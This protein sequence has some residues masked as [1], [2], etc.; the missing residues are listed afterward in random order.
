M[1]RDSLAAKRPFPKPKRQ[2]YTTGARFA[3][4]AA[5]VPIHRCAH[6]LVF[7]C[8]AVLVARDAAADLAD[9]IAAC[10]TVV[11][12]DCAA[13]QQAAAA[14]G[15]EVA[16][17]AKK[18][19]AADTAAPA[20]VKLALA[21]ALLDARDHSDA[22]D[23]AA[24][25]LG[26]APEA[27]DVRAAQARLG[28]GRAAAPLV[29]LLKTSADPHAKLLAAGGLGLLRTK[30]AVERLTAMLRDPSSQLQAEAARALGSIGDPAAELPLLALAGQPKVA[31]PARAAALAALGDLGSARGAALAALLADH[32]T[33]MVAVAALDV[34]R[35]QWKPWMTPAAVAAVQVPG[36]RGACARLALEHGVAAL[37]PHL[38]QVLRK[39]ESEPDEIGVVLLAVA[40]FK[41][42]GAAAAMVERLK[43]AKKPEKIELFRA[44]P[45][46]EDRTVVPDLVPWLQDADNQV[47]AHAVYAL[48]NLTG[49]H[50]GPDVAAWRAYAGL[51][52]K[53][54]TNPQP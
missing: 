22:L 10:P 42:A 36:L 8:A 46:V 4:E 13:L 29:D 9:D 28:D 47:V 52:G 43:A 17:L 44:I 45:K 20:R 23:A 34:V 21:L 31:A 12:A 16:N 27:A 11:F 18:L 53:A 54:L 30:A 51:D 6:A 35:R 15:P 33:K 24:R 7:A 2:A 40:R 48:E 25:P 50:L 14:R 3:P 41:P 26:A 49:R 5:P 1:R 38:M 37:A 19:A 32:P 39:G